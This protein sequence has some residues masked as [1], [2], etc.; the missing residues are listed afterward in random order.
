MDWSGGGIV[1]DV[2]GFSCAGGSGTWG[3]GSRTGGCSGPAS[4][5]GGSSVDDVGFPDKS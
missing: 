2:N 4:G 5:C 3:V 1:S